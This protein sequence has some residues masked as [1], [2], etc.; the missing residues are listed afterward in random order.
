V[1]W[2]SAALVAGLAVGVSG[3]AAQSAADAHALAHPVATDTGHAGT[4]YVDTLHV[5]AVFVPVVPSTARAD[6]QNDACPLGAN[7]RAA[8]VAVGTAFVGT[9]VELFRR[10]RNAWW[11]GERVSFFFRED[12]D[13]DFRDQD[14]FGHMWGAYTLQRGG[15]TLL[16][17]ACVSQRRAVL[18]SA[19]YSTLFQLQIEIWDGFYENFGFSWGDV[20]ANTAGMSLGV[21]H[22]V[23]PS[24]RV[25]KPTISY[26]RTAAMKD[27]RPGDEIRYSIDYA[28]Q[29]FWFSFDVD[30]MLPPAA[31]RYWPG[32]LRLSAGHSV[33]DWVLPRP[34]GVG[35]ETPQQ[36]V[37]GRRQILLSLDLDLSKLPGSHPVWVFFKDQ[38]SYYRLPAPALQITPS[39]D[40][41]RWYR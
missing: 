41:I 17:G 2:L 24:T 36:V 13:Q 6:D 7:R 40:F 16:R 23:R 14:K 15:Y 27:Q 32:L 28:G 9:N 19:L 18:Y 34:A 20:L 3:A 21:L 31:S 29:T 10:F 33:T 25:V 22:A 11:S 8:Q 5:D 35:P 30:A 1:R 39:F 4:D 37:R 38:L 26:S 12:W